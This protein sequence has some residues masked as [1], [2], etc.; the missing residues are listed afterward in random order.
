M[1]IMK[2]IK[3]AQ[4]MLSNSPWKELANMWS[5]VEFMKNQVSFNEQRLVLQMGWH[6]LLDGYK[7]MEYGWKI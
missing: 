6:L 4:N 2:D 3:N 5:Q 7:C 1:N